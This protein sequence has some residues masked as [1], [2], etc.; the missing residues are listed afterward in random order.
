MSTPGKSRLPLL[1]VALLLVALARWLDP[2]SYLKPRAETALSAPVERG[3][4]ADVLV[5]AAPVSA[6]APAT[7]DNAWPVRAGPSDAEKNPGNA[8]LTRAEAAQQEA[9]RH[10]PPPPPPPP[11]YVPPPPPPPPVEPPPPLQVIGTW[12]DSQNM[13]VFLSG[14]QG[15]LLAKPGETLLGQY[16]VQTI[17]KGQLTLLQTGNKRVWTLPIPAAPSTLQTWPGR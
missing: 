3:A 14:P 12:G 2:L 10:P 15:T 7:A 8:F 13:A 16:V 1:L 17:T 5:A 6:S 9:K 4:H 11:P